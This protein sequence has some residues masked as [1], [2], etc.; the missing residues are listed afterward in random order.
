ML[1]D[2]NE[3]SALLSSGH[4]YNQKD[5]DRLSAF[6]ETPEVASEKLSK[7]VKSGT[8]KTKQHTDK[9][10]NYVFEKEAFQKHHVIAISL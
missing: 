10:E 8:W 4:S 3:I 6:F 5:R 1:S 2:E 7:L 9:L